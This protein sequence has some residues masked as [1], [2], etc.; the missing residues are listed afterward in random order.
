MGALRRYKF[1][2]TAIN[3]RKCKEYQFR[4]ITR[5]RGEEMKDILEDVYTECEPLSLCLGYNSRDIRAAKSKSVEVIAIL[6]LMRVNNPVYQLYR[7]IAYLSVKHTS[8]W[9]AVLCVKIPRCY[10]AIEQDIP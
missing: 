5:N 7:C 2:R 1:L 6:I 8:R 10:S 4:Q 9:Y 3:E